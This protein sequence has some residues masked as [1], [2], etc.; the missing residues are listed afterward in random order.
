MKTYQPK[1]KEI[2]RKWH[3]FDAEGKV[4]GRL[5]TEIAG[6]LQGK[7]KVS[8]SRHLDSGD[9]VVVVNSEKVKL[10]GSK[11]LHKVYH[12]HSG[13]PGGLKEVS[14]AQMLEKQ[15]EKIIVKAVSGMLPDN[16]LKRARMARLKVLK[17]DKNPYADK[18]EKT[19]EPEEI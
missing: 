19:A 12:S 16:R 11:K 15:P 8:F 14:F 2:K 4:L 18:I 9:F 1:E 6:L 17:G 13:Y 10:T 5:A 7:G 3:L